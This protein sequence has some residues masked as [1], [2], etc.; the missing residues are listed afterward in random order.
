MLTRAIS[1]ERGGRAKVHVIEDGT[2][3]ADFWKIL[4]GKPSRVKTAEE[5]GSDEEAEKA[6]TKKL[7]HLSDATG[8][9]VFKEVGSGPSIKY[10]QLISED[11]FIYDV[12]AEVFT[13]IGKGA[14]PDEKKNALQYAQDYLK[15]NNRPLFLPITR[16][17][18]GGEN[19]VFKSH[20]VSVQ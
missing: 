8:T 7:F 12:G 20:F 17:L 3:D 2:E 4:G 6:Q 14:S 15:K 16:I 10:N 9:M 5:G 19:G 11:V 1:D 18:E 13:W